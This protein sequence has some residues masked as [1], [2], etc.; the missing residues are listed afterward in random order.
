MGGAGQGM[1]RAVHSA[2][3]QGQAPRGTTAPAHAL[4]LPFVTKAACSQPVHPVIL[5]T[6][7]VGSNGGINNS[8]P[9]QVF[10]RALAA[11]LRR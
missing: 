7:K 8:Q 1:G 9:G 6:S 3:A 5:E 4:Q 11:P 2:V 10:Q